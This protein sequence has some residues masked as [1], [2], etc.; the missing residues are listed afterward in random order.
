MAALPCAVA[1][2]RP[3]LG[4]MSVPKYGALFF[5]IYGGS[6]LLS[7]LYA[8]RRAQRAACRAK[9]AAPDNNIRQAGKQFYLAL[10]A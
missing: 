7:T 2:L 4:M 8:W 10:A 9:V 1:F 3:S 5:L 6:I